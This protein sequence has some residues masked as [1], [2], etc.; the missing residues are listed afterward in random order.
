MLE[1]SV[2]IP[3][4]NA[5]RYLPQTVESILQQTFDDFEVIIINDGSTDDIETWFQASVNDPRFKLISQKNQGTAGA[6]N[7]GIEHSQGTFIAFLDADD[8]WHPRK[9]EEQVR[10]L[11]AHPEVGL[12]YTWLQYADESGTLNGRIVKSSFQGNVWEQLTAF[13]FVGCGS[14]AMIRRTCIEIVGNFDQTLDSYVE[15]WDM[16]LR[17]AKQYPFAVIKEPL[18]YNRK[19]P[20]S[21]STHWKKMAKGFPKVLE[22]AFASAP[23]ELAHLK[24]RSYAHANLCLAWKVLQG[25]QQNYQEDYK[26]ALSFWRKAFF[27]YPS[28]VFFRSFVNMGVLL[29]LLACLGVD[30]Y[31]TIHSFI[32]STRRSVSMLRSS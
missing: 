20:D 18:V 17:V 23:P 19:Y 27:K 1:V 4:Y 26:L 28:I 25:R 6:R 21:F 13:N 2:V 15:D 12:A 24:H 22:K 10:M 8:L 7:T 32:L 5:M 9:L 30:K 3:A 31:R 29:L 14:N 16:W 11:R